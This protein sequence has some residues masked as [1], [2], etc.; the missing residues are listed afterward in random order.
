MAEH[1]HTTPTPT[2]RKSRRLAK[3]ATERRVEPAT[4]ALPPVPPKNAAEQA[5]DREL[6]AQLRG[7]TAQL[8]QRNLENAVLLAQMAAAGRLTAMGEGALSDHFAELGR[9][10][11]ELLKQP[12][13]HKPRRG[14]RVIDGGVA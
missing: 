8:R 9:R 2:V 12:A 1:A 10:F 13:Q 4:F 7:I 6:L 14:L 5:A 3:A 11:S